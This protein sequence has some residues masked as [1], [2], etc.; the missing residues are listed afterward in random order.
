MLNVPDAVIG[1]ADGSIGFGLGLSR[2]SSGHS[3]PK[4]ISFAELPESTSGAPTSRRARSIK[5]RKSR[6][7]SAAKR[8]QGR[9]GDERDDGE[10]PGG[11]GWFSS[12][13]LGAASSKGGAGLP[14][15]AYGYAGLSGPSMGV[16]AEE[17]FGKG[18]GW[19]T[20][21]GYGGVGGVDDWAV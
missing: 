18:V 3:T 16:H 13:L 2:P 15:S 6:S 5:S 1:G 19:G 21:P 20:R 9:E 11:K 4:R 7:R 10:D 12:W 17:R 14:A 8:L